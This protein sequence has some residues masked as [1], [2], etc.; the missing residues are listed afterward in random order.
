MPYEHEH[1]ARIRSPG[2][3]DSSTFRRKP[4]APGVSLV[5]AK[6][7][8]G[9]PMETQSIRFDS[10]R[11]NV[12]EAKAWLARNGYAYTAKFEAARIPGRAEKPIRRV[13]MPVNSTFD[14]RV[15]AALKRRGFK[16]RVARTN[17]GTS[18]VVADA[19]LEAIRAAFKEA[20]GKPR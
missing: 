15:V 6:R 7:G 5:L 4:I 3:F 2:E 18:T 8:P 17:H 19:P 9:Y 13:P 14:A 12:K 20:G 1:S 16:A 10:G 11:F